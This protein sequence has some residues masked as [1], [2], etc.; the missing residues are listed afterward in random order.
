M[1]YEHMLL[2]HKMKSELQDVADHN[3]KTDQRIEKLE[4]IVSEQKEKVSELKEQVSELK[5]KVAALEKEK[6]QDA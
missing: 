5:E 6:E 3:F 1:M 4:K 2:E